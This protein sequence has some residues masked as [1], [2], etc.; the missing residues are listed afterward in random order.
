MTKAE[1]LNSRSP[2]RGS[3][4]FNKHTIF[5]TRKNSHKSGFSMNG[6]QMLPS[7]RTIANRNKR[8]AVAYFFPADDDERS[9]YVYGFQ[10][11]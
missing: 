9:R 10:I 1:L 2:R 8:D 11:P 3:I 5:A 7:P 6:Q 4:A